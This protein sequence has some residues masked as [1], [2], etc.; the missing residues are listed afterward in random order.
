MH[1]CT[2]A[3]TQKLNQTTKELKC[4]HARTHSRTHSRTH[5]RTHRVQP[6]IYIDPAIFFRVLEGASDGVD[7]TLFRRFAE[8][9]HQQH[10]CARGPKNL[11]GTMKCIIVCPVDRCVPAISDTTWRPIYLVRA[12]F[13]ARRRTRSPHPRFCAT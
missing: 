2:H 6:A 12:S 11:R 10:E 4:T 9:R 7:V 8:L 5:P 13:S 3:C 1:A